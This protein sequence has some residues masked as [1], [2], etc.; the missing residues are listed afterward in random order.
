MIDRI[1]SSRKMPWLYEGV[2]TVMRGHGEPSSRV[3]GRSLCTSVHGH[4]LRPGGGAGISGVMLSKPL[5]HLT[6]LTLL[7][8]LS[9]RNGYT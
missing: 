7:L 1:V 6:F 5:L 4:P 8:A 3:A 2:T 9:P